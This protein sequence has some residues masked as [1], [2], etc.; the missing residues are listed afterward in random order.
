MHRLPKHLT[1]G[2]A[3]QRAATNCQAIRI[4]KECEREGRDATP[5]EQSVLSHY[6]GWGQTD[7]R[8][9]AIAWNDSQ[10]SRPDSLLGDMRS[11]Y[12]DKLI[13]DEEIDS[14]KHSALNAHY[15]DPAI[16]HAIWEALYH[17]GL[18]AVPQPN[19]LEP[20][21][22]IGH[23]IGAGPQTS[24]L[25]IGVEKDPL[26]ALIARTLYSEADIR[27][28][29]FEEVALPRVFDVVI[30]NVPFG[31]Y[32]VRDPNHP[33]HLTGSIH[34]YFLTRS[35]NLLRSG[36]IMA[37]ITSRYTLDSEGDH[38][39]KWLCEH[40]NLI[41]S[42]RL[43]SDAFEE[44]AGTQVVTDVLFFS[45]RERPLVGRIEPWIERSEV[46]YKL[47]RPWCRQRFLSEVCAHEDCKY[48][49]G[50]V[51]AYYDAH[52]YMALGEWCQDKLAMGR[53]DGSVGLRTPDGET[54]SIVARFSEAVKHLPAMVMQKRAE[55]TVKPSVAAASTLPP[56]AAKLAALRLLNALRT[57]LD[58][59][60][61]HADGPET[62]TARNSLTL[63]YNMWVKRYGPLTAIESHAQ[64]E[65]ANLITESWWPLL[66]SLET[67]TGARGPIFE[68]RAVT[69]IDRSATKD[70]Q[71]VLYQLLDETG[72]IDPDAI[73]LR[74]GIDRAE[75][76]TALAG[77]VY[78]QGPGGTW[79]TREDF[80]SGDIRGKIATAQ[81]WASVD[82]KFNEYVEHLTAALPE[83]IKP[84]D[85]GVPIGAP[86]VPVEIYKDF[87]RHLFPR[88]D[89]WGV[90]IAHIEATG[91]WSLNV[92]NR[93]ILSSVENTSRYG[94]PRMPAVDLLRCALR[95]K[96]PIVYDVT[97]D[98]ERI[99]NNEETAKAMERLAEIRRQ[100]DGWIMQRGSDRSQVLARIY[101]EKFNGWRE[102]S[103]DGSHLT[104]PGLTA[105]YKGAPLKFRPHQ[106]GGALRII[107]KGQIDESVLLTY[108]VGLGKSL[109]L[110]LGV[111]KRLQLGLSRKA[112]VVVPKHTLAQWR[113]EWR[114][115]YP[116]HLDWLLCATDD[117]FEPANRRLFLS[118]ACTSDAKIILMT[119]DQCK[120]IPLRPA[121][122]EAYLNR[123]IAELESSMIG[124]A[125]SSVEKKGMEREL[126]KRQK[127]LESFKVK[128]QKR[129]DK[130]CA[131]RDGGTPITWEDIDAD[132]VVHD[133]A[134]ALKNAPTATRM[135]GIAGLARA[136][137][138]RA[139]DNMMK[140]HYITCPELF[141]GL[142]RNSDRGGKVIGLTGTPLTN[143]LAEAWVMMK[144]YQPRLLKRLGFWHFDDWARTFTTPM[145][146]A[147][148]D[149][150]GK[151]RLATRLKFQNIPEL[152]DI[153]GQAWDRASSDAE[154]PKLVGGRMGI[155]EVA[156]SQ[157]LREYN[158]SLAERADAVRRRKVDPSED[159]MLKITHDGRLASLFNGPPSDSWKP[160]AYTPVDACVDKVWD[161]YCHSD[162]KRGLQLIFC[163][164][165]TPKAASDDD[166]T[167]DSGNH[168]TPEEIF[169][170]QGVY[171]VI[172][173]RLYAHG[174]MNGEVAYIHDAASDSDK[175]RMFADAN[176]G[177]IRVLIGST[178]K[179]GTGVNVQERA[180]ACH[181]LTVPWRPDWLEQAEGRV[182]RPGNLWSEVYTFAYPTIGSYAVVLW[183]FIEQKATFIAQI[184]N[185]TYRSRK[186]DDIGDIIIDAATA[187]AIALGNPAIIARTKI[188]MRL[189]SITRSYNAWVA[190]CRNAERE[191]DRLPRDI[192]EH[193]KA[194]DAI[195]DAI[196]TRDANRPVVTETGGFSVALN[197][198]PDLSKGQEVVESI[199][200][201][202][203]RIGYLADCF[204]RVRGKVETLIGLY[205]G[206]TLSLVRRTDGSIVLG[207]RS[208]LG[209]SWEI[210]NF[211]ANDVFVILENKLSNLEYDALKLRNTLTNLRERLNT[212][213]TS[214]PMWTERD[215]ALQLLSEYLPACRSLAQGGIVECKSQE[216]F[217][218][219]SELMAEH[220]GECERIRAE[221]M[222]TVAAQFE[223]D[224]AEET[225]S[226][227]DVDDSDEYNDT[228][229]DDSAEDVVVDLV[230]RGV[231]PES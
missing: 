185:R 82:P 43:P 180:L 99:K 133:E 164:M 173:D 206:L 24:G 190:D 37:L 123:E 188:E 157:E 212:L 39:R 204:G 140:I 19:I 230:L 117:S 113:A 202:R 9:K 1:Y 221:H 132:M 165:H 95:L 103:W 7:V 141:P 189:P 139:V 152:L 72:A 118:R 143:T 74:C 17:L 198:D 97:E 231:W 86:W 196:R 205:R 35:L 146:D 116:G 100:W 160:T 102:R 161:L 199:Q 34:N 55:P 14:I 23:F 88:F 21:C 18:G 136:E 50:P 147:E 195:T 179:L 6:V 128:Q 79:T 70:P 56:S 201:A 13:T 8:S 150:V 216:W 115:F 80:L 47:G 194:L 172:R 107:E 104:F 166:D 61:R 63:S 211:R 66:R 145:Q 210:H 153:L 85:I 225:R 49:R 130:I 192:A 223:S 209:W 200:I 178:Q 137:S 127:A 167:D 208:P 162:S 44:N 2:N 48:A 224:P 96:V 142:V 57:L 155:V 71:G 62:R 41:G 226:I 81:T 184:V 151:L 84:E 144:I 10:Y 219:F 94:T 218:V 158:N 135:S 213:E 59:E 169:A 111:M 174:V 148:F 119:Y 197:R 93:S 182:R 29:G 28:A 109:T 114:T 87:L 45:A 27:T 191:R 26:T 40:G 125:E 33:D 75:V 38:V 83:P 54:R 215:N 183:Q 53:T 20:S 120:A 51:G 121:T 11:L 60:R 25:L 149:A 176:A 31:N 78:Q 106:H 76:L 73:S 65:A 159:N 112:V 220:V 131:G 168:L 122:F 30:G 4:A 46:S 42:I 64:G 52:P 12:D 67:A 222:A 163:D 134:Q 193:S 90:Q 138:Q 203:M 15:T 110:I 105:E 77:V 3:A 91:D 175:L 154:K 126:K 171:G 129:W 181:H 156:G 16:V 186:A 98:G 69:L 214:Q 5:A 170:Q 227:D 32:G 207:V 68:R 22:G 124:V 58:C 177:R 89:G 187:K 228:E 36:G 229:S 101:N 108:A 92:T 217:G